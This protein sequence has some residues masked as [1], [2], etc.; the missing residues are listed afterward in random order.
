MQ[1]CGPAIALLTGMK[2][3][4]LVRR[5]LAAAVLL[6]LFGLYAVNTTV[7]WIALGVF[8]TVLVARKRG[9]AKA[10]APAT[11]AF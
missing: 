9:A 2:I 11:T 4:Q 3:P 6:T 10:V 1:R 5:L 7:G 8:A